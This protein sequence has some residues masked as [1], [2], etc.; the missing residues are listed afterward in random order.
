MVTRFSGARETAPNR[1]PQ[2]VA[3]LVARGLGEAPRSGCL[4]YIRARAATNAST[5]RFTSAVVCPADIWVRMRALP[6]GTTG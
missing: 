3:E 4:T 2:A 5:A 6:C 1:P